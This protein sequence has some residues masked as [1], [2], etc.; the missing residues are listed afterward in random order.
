MDE[1]MLAYGS[2]YAEALA[3]VMGTWNP[4][5]PGRLPTGKPAIEAQS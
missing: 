5:R 3:K 4:D 2:T 1:F